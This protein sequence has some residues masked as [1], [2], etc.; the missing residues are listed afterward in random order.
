MRKE[1]DSLSIIIIEWGIRGKYNGESQM[2]I[3]YY[4]LIIDAIDLRGLQLSIVLVLRLL[5]RA[6]FLLRLG[7]E[8]FSLGVDNL[9]YWLLSVDLDRVPE[10]FGGILR[11]R[12]DF[13]LWLAE[14]TLCFLTGS[15]L[16]SSPPYSKHWLFLMLLWVNTSNTV[17]FCFL[18]YL[19]NNNQ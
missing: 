9:F 4:Y 1:V 12:L 7:G 17:F 16:Y 6:F 14:W 2:F 13:T 3:W 18:N 19:F 8:G 5:V 10:D 11:D 15:A